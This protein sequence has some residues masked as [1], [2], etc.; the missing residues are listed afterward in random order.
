MMMVMK[1]QGLNGGD[2]GKD[3]VAGQD[4]GRKLRCID[5]I[6]TTIYYKKIPTVTNTATFNTPTLC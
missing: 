6:N 2:G 4:G 3:G 5:G 1:I